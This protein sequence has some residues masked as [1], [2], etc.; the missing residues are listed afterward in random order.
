MI[1]SSEFNQC[2]PL[3]DAMEPMPSQGATCDTYRVKLYGKLHFLKRLKPE[4]ASNVR[5]REALRKEF[6]TGF[7]L[8]HPHL[9]RYVSFDGEGILMENIDGETLSALLTNNPDYFSK[10][11]QTDRLL[12]QLL[13]V[14]HYL[15]SHQI[16]HLDLKPDNIMVTRINHD[17]K[18]IDFGCCLTDTFNDTQGRTD[19]FAAPEQL[20]GGKTDIRT[21]LYAIGK[22]IELFPNHTIYNRVIAK[23]IA[24]D[25][26]KRFQ[27]TDELL[28]AILPKRFFK[29]IYLLPILLVIAI[30]FAWLMKREQT[31]P[32]PEMAIDTIIRQTI[33]QTDTIAISNPKPK[34]PQRKVITPEE[35]MRQELNKAILRA[36][37]AT[38]ATF[39]DSIFP[40]PQ[41]SPTAGRA[42]EMATQSF[43][44]QVMNI[45]DR[46]SE[47]YPQIPRATIQAEA[48]SQLQNH[49]A[50]IFS[51][52]RAN[53]EK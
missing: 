19:R 37:N 3:Y 20:N 47:E 44:S 10:K 1:E 53:H 49:I 13:D 38:I 29:L 50:S 9:V 41:P 27:S 52:M 26:E 5:Y 48:Q 39:N 46:L 31:V 4:F 7:R 34:E 33:I 18:L 17:V 8:E 11:S 51:R 30:S 42:W 16:V 14:L 6:E 40:P 15:H 24:S 36:Y 21:D 43:S 32:N 2:Q 23:C 25:K 45:V 22:I 28:K 35:Q 12:C